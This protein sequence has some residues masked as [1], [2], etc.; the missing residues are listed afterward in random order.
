MYALMTVAAI[1][2]GL[3]L[4][5]IS[6]NALQGINT[7]GGSMWFSQ[8][9]INTTCPLSQSRFTAFRPFSLVSVLTTCSLEPQQSTPSKSETNYYRPRVA[10]HSPHNN[11]YMILYICFL[12]WI[13]IFFSPVSFS[14]SS[15]LS[16]SPARLFAIVF[17]RPDASFSCTWLERGGFFN[18]SPCSFGWSDVP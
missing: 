11:I 12:L 13:Y 3:M 17:I 15:L 18:H 2:H 1:G 16:V 10:A 7:L 8:V 5:P 14:S 4:D 6:R 9:S